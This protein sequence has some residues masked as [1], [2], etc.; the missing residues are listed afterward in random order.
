MCMLSCICKLRYICRCSNQKSR[1]MTHFLLRFMA[2]PVP[3]PRQ[4]RKASLC[5]SRAAIAALW[6][7]EY[8]VL[9]L[10]L[11]YFNSIQSVNSHALNR[12]PFLK[13]KLGYSCIHACCRR[14]C[15]CTTHEYTKQERDC[16]T[17]NWGVARDSP[18]RIESD[19]SDP[20]TAACKPNWW[21][22]ILSQ[23]LHSCAWD[24]VWA[25]QHFGSRNCLSAC[26]GNLRQM[27][28]ITK[29]HKAH[30][31]FKVLG[32][33]TCAGAYAYSQSWLHVHVQSGIFPENISVFCDHCPAAPNVS[34]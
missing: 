7:R 34:G 11:H 30:S 15:V 22:P 4:D 20:L 21:G 9:K 24:K 14:K 29:K 26:I 5:E 31:K 16:D 2:N 10:A 23:K 18:A 17:W 8:L 27:L 1:I 6:F 33:K 13:A 32:V 12:S 25:F 3:A 28:C 19:G